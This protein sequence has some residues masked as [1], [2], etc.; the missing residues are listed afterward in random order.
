MFGS[1][2]KGYNLWR[3][4]FN[5]VRQNIPYFRLRFQPDTFRQGFEKGGTLGAESSDQGQCRTPHPWD[6]IVQRRYQN[7]SG[8]GV[9]RV[10]G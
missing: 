4:T 9:A 10:A 1:A 3:E 2:R 6:R 5:E 7:A 8:F